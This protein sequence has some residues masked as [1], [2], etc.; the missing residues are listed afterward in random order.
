MTSAADAGVT[1]RRGV[2]DYAIWA[3]LALVLLTAAYLVWTI[4]GANKATTASTPA[5]RAVQDLMRAVERAPKD[6]KARVRLAEALLAGGQID[7][8]VVQ[9][10]AALKLDPKNIDAM[11]GLGLVS[12][13][14]KNFKAAQ[15]YWDRIIKL[16][17][18]GT[19]EAQDNRLEAAY[20]YM[21]LSLLETKQPDRAVGYF[22]RASRIHDTASDT[23][24]A[25]SVA[26]GRLGRKAEQKKEL[27]ITLTLDPKAPEANY[28]LGSIA[29]A[30]GD[31][32]AAAD[33]FR[34]SADSAEDATKPDAALAKLGSASDRTAAARK[35][36]AA[37][38]F[39][40]A[41]V[42]ARIAAALAPTD[43]KARLLLAQAYQAAGNKAMAIKVYK[44]VLD[45]APGDPTATAALR[46]LGAK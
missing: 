41:L 9:F 23:H 18:G 14:T 45:S 1:K 26:Y 20:Y 30:E 8:G 31:Q 33:F 19:F 34:T 17:E 7:E 5:S 35:L 12:M 6:P 32:A 11:T 13:R 16:T 10:Q 44:V 38:D 22:K 43:P 27:K 25:L 37:R 39:K 3:V 36:M 21:G 2:L 40:K 28:D 42:E 4:Y 46:K 15:G 29:L 24:Y